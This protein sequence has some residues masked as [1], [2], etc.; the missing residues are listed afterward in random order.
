MILH[1]KEFC[2]LIGNLKMPGH[3]HQNWWY[4]LTDNI[5]VYLYAKN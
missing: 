4:Q 3:A 5:D 2:N 1:F